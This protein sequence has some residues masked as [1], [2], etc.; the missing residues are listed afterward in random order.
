[1]NLPI[2][3]LFAAALAIIL[4]ALTYHVIFARAKLGVSILHAGDMALATRI[5]RHGNFV[6]TV[7]IA[8]IVMALAE[9]GGANSTALYV[10]GVLLVLGR[11]AHPLGLDP[12][13]STKPLRIIGGVATHLSI[14]ICIVLIALQQFT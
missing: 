12:E 10:A 7:P 13:V 9:L 8:L 5:R 6:E 4:L 11:I 2:T 3:S 1:M 14:A